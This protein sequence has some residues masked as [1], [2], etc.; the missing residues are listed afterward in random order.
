MPPQQ[1]PTAAQVVALANRLL[2][3]KACAGWY[4][5][6]LI[7]DMLKEEAHAAVREYR[8]KDREELFEL[9]LRAQIAELFVAQFFGR[10]ESAIANAEML[11]WFKDQQTSP[12]LI[13]ERVAGSY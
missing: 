5:L 10:I 2:A 13:N 1:E 8:G 6:Q 4:D 7:G 9:N 3:Q 12:P 11:P